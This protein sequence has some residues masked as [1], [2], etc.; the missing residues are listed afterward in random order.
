MIVKSYDFNKL[1]KIGKNFTY[2]TE[3]I[4]VIKVKL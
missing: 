3:T 4:T 2:F 1:K